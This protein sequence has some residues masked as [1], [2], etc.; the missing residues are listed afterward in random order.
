MDRKMMQRIIVIILALVMVLS[1][2]APVVMATETEAETTEAVVRGEFECGDDMTWNYED[3]T[4]TIAGSGEMDDYEEDAP[5]GQYKKEITKVVFEG[6]VTYIGA[7]AFNNYDAIEEVD[8]GTA[9]KEIGQQAFRSCEGLT[10]I[11]LP[12]TFR[13][14][15]VE[16]F[17][18]CTNLKEIHCSGVFPSFKE[19]C[20][21]AV[22]A[23][24]YYPA[25][26]PWSVTYIEQLETAFK[27]RIEFLDSNGD[28]HFTPTEATEATEEVTEAT[29]EATTEP[30]V[31]TTVETEEVTEATTE[32]TT[33][34]TTE[35][36]TIPT[37]ESQPETIEELLPPQ[38]AEEE[39]GSKG[40][41]GLVIVGGV[42]FLLALGGLA[43][44]KKKSKKGKFSRR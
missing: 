13:I 39:E 6:S 5:W 26:N 9:L 2:V 32:V 21:W 42:V 31:E 25:A 28:D 15:G 3:G 11:Y 23:T 40:W 17:N 34:P 8:F 10:E 37:E 14:F 16:S 20:L 30:V 12:K 24:I 4:L 36:T 29:T 19:N 33:E 35:P 38:A 27:G 43:F 1:V 22:Y 41:I 18:S 44:G 7:R